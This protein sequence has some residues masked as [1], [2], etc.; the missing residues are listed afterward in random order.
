M[1]FKAD[2]Q[3]SQ[4]KKRLNLPKLQE[5]HEN[6][7]NNYATSFEAL[8]TEYRLDANMLKESSLKKSAVYLL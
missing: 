5:N 6:F 4:D 3:F 8:K 7:F 1:S 2:V